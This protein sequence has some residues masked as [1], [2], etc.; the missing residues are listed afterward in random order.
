MPPSTRPIPQFFAEPP[1]EPLPYGR[2][3]EALEGHLLEAARRLEDY[4]E[5]GEPGTAL[6]FPERTLGRRTYVPATVDT[7]AGFELF[8]FVS[9][10]RSGERA[11]AADFKASVDWTDVTIADNPDWK[12]DLSEAELGHWRGHD[13]RRGELTLVWGVSHVSGGDIA[14]AELGPTITDQCAVIE[15]RFTLASLDD[16]TGDYVEVRLW[17]KR[18]RELATESLY[19]D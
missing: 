13:G 14:T 10:T 9:Y 15:D 2:W 8:G 7:D 3:A 11:E 18:N 6:W 12:L 4:G 16:Y 5:L 17:D 19:E 1:Q